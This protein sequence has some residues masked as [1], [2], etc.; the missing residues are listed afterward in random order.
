MDK[1]SHGYASLALTETISKCTLPDTSSTPIESNDAP[2]S[3]SLALK[4]PN[5]LLGEIFTH[6]CTES[7]HLS[8]GGHPIWDLLQVCSLWRNVVQST[9][10]LWADFIIEQPEGPRGRVVITDQCIIWRTRLCLEFSGTVPLSIVFRPWRLSG[11]VLELAAAHANRWETFSICEST[12]N[13]M[14]G[15]RTIDIVKPQGLGKLRR[16]DISE[17]NTTSMNSNP[18]SHIY[19]NATILEELKVECIKEFRYY[20]FC[21]TL[22]KLELV[23]CTVTEEKITFVLGNM[24]LL[25]NLTLNET[26]IIR[27]TKP[28]QLV[29]LP[30]LRTLSCS[31]K[32]DEPIIW[33]FLVVPRLS[34][35]KIIGNIE[36]GVVLSTI[37]RSRCEIKTLRLFTSCNETILS[38]LMELPYIEHLTLFSLDNHRELLK[39]LVWNPQNSEVLLLLPLLRRLDTVNCHNYD[40]PLLMEIMRSRSRAL[41]SG[42]TATNN[43][44]PVPLS[45]FKCSAEIVNEDASKEYILAIC[46]LGRDLGVEVEVAMAQWNPRIYERTVQQRYT[47]YM[48]LW[49]KL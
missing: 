49:D 16:L 45:H 19:Q 28:S 20:P 38:I 1:V 6:V 30:S 21:K 17:E 27:G 36:A 9:P 14:D 5:E 35:I 26:S 8:H 11:I 43:Y 31:S 40:F 41:I 48:H 37:K 3:Q 44:A 12:L 15:F 46:N 18:A 10:I 34:N 23:C 22:K 29:T 4:L 24:P 47:H 13:Q 32:F 25:E 33:S 42:S 7:I 39:N 2:N